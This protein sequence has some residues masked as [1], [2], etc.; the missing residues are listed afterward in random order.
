MRALFSAF[1]WGVLLM[2]VT[3]VLVFGILYLKGRQ[4]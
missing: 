4:R 1:V 3:P 2:L